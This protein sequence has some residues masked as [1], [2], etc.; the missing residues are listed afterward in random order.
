[1]KPRA[2]V[3]MDTHPELIFPV[4]WRRESV[5]R[6][7]R[8]YDLGRIDQREIDRVEARLVEFRRAR[9]TFAGRVIE[10]A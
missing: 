10:A 8:L 1:M 5:E 6:Y 2:G 3:L 9:D 4:T 7:M